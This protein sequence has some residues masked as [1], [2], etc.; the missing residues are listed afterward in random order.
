MQITKDGVL[1]CMHDVTLER[2]TDVE[3]RFPQRSVLEGD[4]R[5]WYI[6][7]FTLSEIKS[8][9]AGSWFS[10]QHR[11]ARVPT[12]QELIDLVKGKAGILPETKE[13]E[14]YGR[15]GFDMERL[16]LDSLRKNNLD[17]PMTGANR[18]PAIIQ[19]FSHESL[20]RLKSYGARVPL[21]LLV[22]SENASILNAGSIPDIRQYAEGIGPS[23][24][25]L[26]AN[27]E[28]V[29]LAHKAG[30]SV[31]PY[32][33]RNSDRTPGFASVRDEMAHF[34]NQLGVDALFTDN[35]DQF[36]R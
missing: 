34:L 7:D 18:S 21:M 15:R 28:I 29:L 30:L 10:T 25:I 16:V 20:K 17:E 35:P 23:K 33:F 14:V 2:T 9:D 27:P 3:E 31:T 19:S 22:S 12:F 6:A 24:E 1:I 13:P 11:G 4:A 32:T 26:L 36:P 8:L 5:H